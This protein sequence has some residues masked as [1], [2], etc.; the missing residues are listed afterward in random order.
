VLP[1]TEADRRH[2]AHERA[3]E[4]L[5]GILTK[6]W[7][8]AAEVLAAAK[9]A[10]ISEKAY[11][12]A[13][14][15]LGVQKKRVG[16]WGWGESWWEI[17]KPTKEYMPHAGG[18]YTRTKEFRVP[19]EAFCA[20]LGIYLA[21]G[22]VRGDRDDIIVSQ[23]PNSPDLEE[24]RQIMA[25]TGLKW[26]YDGPHMK[27]T[28]SNKPLGTWLRT[29]CGHR[30]W[31][32]LVPQAFKELPPYLLE[33][34]LHAMMLGDGH[35]GP[36][37]QGRYTTTSGQLANDVQEIFQKLGRDAWIRRETTK[38]YPGRFGNPETK[39]Q[40]YVVRERLQ[41]YHWLP[42][43]KRTRYS[44]RVHCVTVPNGI[45]YVRRNGKAGWCGDSIMHPSSG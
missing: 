5:V 41:D 27:F 2:P 38:D 42:I 3:T 23:S 40:V 30:A 11:L 36:E 15:N 39:R 18:A 35:W 45:V 20:F 28:V 10:G 21:E 26:H 22:W 34:M 32:K 25:T 16:G 13:R 29:N 19:I 33:T 7:T 37:G 43:P 31:N 6:D 8:P 1:G 24:I 17:S 4:W 14:K 44:G 9:L 12:A